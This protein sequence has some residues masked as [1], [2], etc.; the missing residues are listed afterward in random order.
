MGSPNFGFS[1]QV[2]SLCFGLVPDYPSDEQAQEWIEECGD[3]T[4]DIEHVKTWLFDDEQHYAS[5]MRDSLFN[6]VSERVNNVV[7]K[8]WK[9]DELMGE[10][11][12]EFPYECRLNNGYHEGWAMYIEGRCVDRR[13]EDNVWNAYLAMYWANVFKPAD[14]DVDRYIRATC[15]K[16]GVPYVSWDNFKAHVDEVLDAVL[17]VFEQFCFASHLQGVTGGWTGGTYKVEA[18]DLKPIKYADKWA[19]MF[20][21]YVVE[22]A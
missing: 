5:E 16:Y 17:W 1:S 15:E 9:F 18:S 6:E 19:E 12:V 13:D 3:G 7:G 8:L 2:F 20:P 4:E 22:K 14:G 11:G 21:E 10:Y